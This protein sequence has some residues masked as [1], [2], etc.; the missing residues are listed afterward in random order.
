MRRSEEIHALNESPELFLYVMRSPRQL[1]VF[2][3]ADLSAANRGPSGSE[4]TRV[5]VGKVEGEAPDRIIRI[6]VTRKLQN[7]AEPLSDLKGSH[8][9]AE[10][11]GASS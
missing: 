6:T 8:S 4:A 9:L 2:P 5:K 11:L 3:R 7:H 1:D 10:S